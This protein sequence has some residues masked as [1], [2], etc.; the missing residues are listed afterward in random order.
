MIRYCA[1]VAPLLLALPAL[2]Q[3]CS[4]A[5]PEGRQI[6]SERYSLGFRTHPA[7]IEAGRHFSVEIA[8]CPKE[9]GAGPISVRVDA[10]M[11]EH[12]HGM[13]YE[14][15]VRRAATTEASA[16][17]RYHAEGLMFHMPGRW[18][19]VFDLRSE[20]KTDRLTRSV[21]LE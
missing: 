7:K 11:P 16:V 12:R 2:A 5:L 9:S 8:V 14:A 21:L 13:N 1:L 17:G 18:E 6:E 10:H 3:T 15:S 4:S 19:F 20:G